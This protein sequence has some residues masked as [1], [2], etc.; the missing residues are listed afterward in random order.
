[1]QERSNRAFYFVLL[2]GVISLFADMTYEAA[3]SITGPYLAILGAS[4]TVVGVVA[5]LGEL[6]GYGLRL[7]AGIISDRTGKYWLITIT[8]YAVNLLAVPALALAGNWEVASCLIVAERFGKA[9]R[10]PARDAMLS[11]ARQGLGSGRVFGL[12]EAMDQIGA[13]TG[14]LVVA[15]VLAWK[16]SYR[17][18]FAVLAVPAILALAVLVAARIIFPQPRDMEPSFHDG[19][20]ADFDANFWVYLAAVAF[21]ALGF[22][23]YPL[24]AFHMKVSGFFADRWIPVVYACAMGVDAL[25]ALVFGRM[26]DRKGIFVL[27]VMAVL[28]AGCASLVFLGGPMMLVSGMML[29]GVAMGAQESV[30]RA[31]VAD[32]VPS[33][34]RATGYGMFNAGFGLAWFMGS[35]AMGMLYDRSLIGLAVFS[36]AAQLLSVP[37]FYA[38]SKSLNQNRRVKA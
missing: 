38:S 2:L 8:G 10:T 25:S 27:M 31:V 35:A 23:D 22:F 11:H 5:G 30:I 13:M 15:G 18:G 4:A 16:G 3:R 14:P 29:W 37:L 6:V 28:S 12:H 32:I 24:A 9:V 34:R 26:Y 20:Q 1:M 21:V 17:Y 19:K 7:V 33:D 36:G